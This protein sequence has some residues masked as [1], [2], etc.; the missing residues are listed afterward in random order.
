LTG[1]AGRRR[2]LAVI[3]IWLCAVSVA[4]VITLG[5]TRYVS[6]L[7]RFLPAPASP[8]EELMLAQLSDGV[9]ARLVLIGIDG[10]RADDV[11]AASRVLADRLRA[12]GLFRYVA[13]GELDLRG[14]DHGALLRW[15]YHLSPQMTPERF[16]VEGL[17]GAIARRAEELGSPLGALVRPWI[18]RDPTGEMIALLASRA[19]GEGPAMRDGVWFDETRGRAIL[20]AHAAATGYDFGAVARLEAGIAAAFALASE[21]RAGL[22]L[23]VTGPSIF[24]HRS[25]RAIERDAHW[26]ASAA[27]VAVMLILAFAYRSG[28]LT[29]LA[30]LP[31]LTGVVVG[32]AAVGGVF[33]ACHIITIGFGATLIGEAVDYPTYLFMQ[34]RDGEAPADAARRLWPTLRLAVLTTVLGAIAMVASSFQGVAQLGVFTLVGVGVAGVVT[35]YVLPAIAPGSGGLPSPRAFGVGRLDVFV[36]FARRTRMAVPAMFVIAVVALAAQADRVWERDLERINPIADQDKLDDQA[37]REALGAPDVRYLVAARGDTVDAVMHRFE[38]LADPLA[39]LARSG[40]IGGHD[41]PARYLPSAETQRARLGAIPPGDVLAARVAQATRDSPFRE[42]LFGPFLDEVAQ[43]RSG[44][45][46]TLDALEGTAWRAALD[47]LVVRQGGRWTGLAPLSVVR[48]AP[49][50]ERAIEG[51]RD[52]DVF[53]FD[54]KRESDGLLSRHSRRSLALGGVGLAII[55]A[56]L[57]GGRG[58]HGVARILVPVLAAMAATAALLVSVGTALTFLHVVSLVLVLGTGVNYAL[59]FAASGPDADDRNRTTR[60]VVVATLTTLVGFGV[61]SFAATPVLHTIGVT[62]ALGAA[63]SFLFAAAWSGG[64]IARAGLLNSPA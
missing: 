33:G 41:S 50:V 45:L 47:A 62:V 54:L 12:S 15:R 60:A 11:V 43:A 3:G 57:W 10:P 6:D 56:V 63:L 53:F 7:S 14:A 36:A 24:A 22:S 13:N 55:A 29:A 44:S 17:Q 9:A 34:R 58:V 61:L 2:R 26:L 5:H 25:Q 39:T 18:A 42:G 49:A 21:G 52:P 59:F 8:A 31:A 16:T 1:A 28:R 27:A 38:Q 46:V 40:A 64:P 23:V 30:F 19:T 32:V 35:R 37:L 20:M 51:L 48:D 4:L